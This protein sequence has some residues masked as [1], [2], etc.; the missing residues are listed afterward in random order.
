[1]A[2]ISPIAEKTDLVSVKIL[3][4]GQEIDGKYQVMSIHIQNSVNRIP[5]AEIRILDGSTSKEDFAISD[6]EDFV[7]GNSI[8][9]NAGY[10]GTNKTVFS[11]IIIKHSV[12]IVPNKGA[13]LI[14]ECRDN[15]IK[16]TIGRK[17]AAFQDKT[18][19]DVIGSIIDT[20][21]LTKSIEAT[22]PVLPEI[23]Q[24]YTSDWD[25]MLSR[26][27]V[28]GQII[29]V[30]QGKITMQKP[31]T[32]TAPLLVVNY[33]ESLYSFE[34]SIDA[35]TQL[36]AVKCISWDMKTQQIL[37]ADAVDPNLSLPGNLT[38]KKLATVASPA[39]FLLQSTVPLTK[40][41]LQNWANAS[42]TKSQLAKVTGRARFQGNALI[43]PGL[44]LEMGG[45]GNRFAG[46]AFVSSTEHSIEHGDWITEVQ[47]GLSNEWFAETQANIMSAP[48]A[49]LIPGI[50]GMQIGTV[51]QIQDDPQSE[52]RVLVK[53]PL[54][55]TDSKGIWARMVNPYA[56]TNA[57]IFFYPEKG[58]EV[59]LGFLNDDPRF[60]V[61]L[62]SVFS[63]AKKPPFTP[64]E[65]N[66]NKGIITN[67]QLKV[68]FD[69]EN[70]ITSITTPKN[71][72]IILSEQDEKITITDQNK[73]VITMSADGI[74]IKSCKDVE[75]TAPGD[76]TLKADGNINAKAT[77]NVSI[78]G[79]QFSAKA[80]TEA[81]V[82]GDGTAELTASGNVTVKGAMVM[83]N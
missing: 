76:I 75:I 31:D 34:A 58:D 11:G 32:S 77:A 28:N 38:S 56:T 57:G 78:K 30:D 79:S 20:Y 17:N 21:S 16:M 46:N 25:F 60:P 83:I 69:D 36:S 63:S 64:D 15:A 54:I 4:N 47:L 40:D 24:Y 5:Q 61:I 1:M 59:L 41:D 48:A 51:V 44:L 45:L 33:G 35:R 37:E 53:I 29:I 62:G 23:V 49:S 43:K 10:H 73:N 22:T 8:T 7:P 2:A 14:I 74:I 42:L 26:A 67:K 13:I 81:T 80:D 19:S 18:D 50:Q 55:S 27:D 9:L 82:H 70:L 52:F 68:T 12:K 6:S 71:N 3:T 65:K 39:N 72:S 66:T